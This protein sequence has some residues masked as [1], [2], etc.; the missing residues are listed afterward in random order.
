M[1]RRVAA[2]AVAMAVGL[3]IPG[4]TVSG[5][6]PTGVAARVSAAATIP[7]RPTLTLHDLTVTEGSD[8]RQTPA[9]MRITLSEPAP[10]P[11][12]VAWS[13]GIVIP[14]Q[15]N[16]PGG[17]VTIP[18]GAVEATLPLRVV[19][20]RTDEPDE[21][22]PVG[23]FTGSGYAVAR[24]EATLRIRDDDAPT[25]D[26]PPSVW[27]DLGVGDENT[28]SARAV[29]NLSA[30]AQHTVIVHYHTVDVSAVAGSD[31][32]AK[33]SSIVFR[34]GETRHVL[35]FQLLNDGVPERR[36]HFHIVISKV[37]GGIRARGNNVD[38]YDFD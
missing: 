8:G 6:A 9:R 31:Y 34:P 37:D 33:R 35:R 29:I 38:I 28:S 10:E 1:K 5:A 24:A 4:S 18:T 11:L 16:P 15:F 13:T 25:A 21:E 22:I 17:V 2:I 23:I 14:Y 26:P 30:P 27:I 19:A 32:V 36:E 7:G 20:D 12:T 3:V